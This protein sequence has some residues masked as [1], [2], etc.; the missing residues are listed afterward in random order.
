MHEAEAVGK[1]S[2]IALDPD[3]VDKT[4]TFVDNAA[5]TVKSAMQRDVEQGRRSEMESIIGVIKR[6]GKDLRVPTPVTDP[7]YAAL[8]PGER[9]ATVKAA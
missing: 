3:I 4:M 6:K 5:P 1:A 8:L 2:G 9:R 7:I